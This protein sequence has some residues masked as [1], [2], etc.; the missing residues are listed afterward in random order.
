MRNKLIERNKAALVTLNPYKDEIK[1]K[2]LIYC[3]KL[4]RLMKKAQTTL[5]DGRGKERIIKAILEI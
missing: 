2:K 4:R 3:H 5:V 1:V